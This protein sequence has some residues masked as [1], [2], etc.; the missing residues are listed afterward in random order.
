[1]TREN[2][3]FKRRIGIGLG[4]T[5]LLYIAYICGVMAL[6]TEGIQ[7]TNING[8]SWNSLFTYHHDFFIDNNGTIWCYY[9]KDSPSASGYLLCSWDNGTTWTFYNFL[10]AS[11]QTFSHPHEYDMVYNTN[12]GYLYCWGS[13]YSTAYTQFGVYTLNSN[14]TFTA[15]S[16]MYSSSHSY[17]N[18]FSSV[19]VDSNGYAYMLTYDKASWDDVKLHK[20]GNNDG[21]FN[22]ASGYPLSIYNSTSANTDFKYNNLLIDSNDIVYCI[23][24]NDTV[25]YITPV[26]SNK[27]GTRTTITLN[28]AD[29]SIITQMGLMSS[30]I[31]DDDIIHFVWLDDSNNIVYN[32]Y[33]LSSGINSPLN[34]ATGQSNSQPMITYDSQANDIYVTWFEGTLYMRNYTNLETW[35]TEQAITDSISNLLGNE[36]CKTF[37]KSMGNNIYHVYSQTSFYRSW[38]LGLIEL[39]ASRSPPSPP[40]TE[41]PPDYDALFFYGGVASV[42]LILIAL[43]ISYSKINRK[44]F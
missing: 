24:A 31:D 30:T 2:F 27:I 26:Q 39:D 34:I 18:A 12:D 38:F 37:E 16:G 5:F 6:V 4:L 41:S 8:E 1:M 40:V 14:G 7:M 42:I 17:Q 29:S 20:N 36:Y 22:L 23:S 15:L 25:A 13:G 32:N 43:V 11:Y 9:P 35:E 33:S 44:G 10:G 3:N 21:T 19:A 28:I